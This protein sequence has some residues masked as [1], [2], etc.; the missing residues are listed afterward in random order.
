MKL[1]KKALKERSIDSEE[2][3]LALA[4]HLSSGGAGS[5]FDVLV[6]ELEET[7]RDGT[8]FTYGREEYRVLTDEE[9]DDAFIEYQQQLWDEMGLDSFSR[10]FVDSIMRNNVDEK[11]FWRDYNDGVYE[12]I[13][14]S[15]ESYASYFDI[16]DLK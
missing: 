4:T 5:Q 13:L 8:E 3:K 6:E 16:D 1:I 10:S 15:P 7:G 2:R 14:D 12:M 11:A 9:A